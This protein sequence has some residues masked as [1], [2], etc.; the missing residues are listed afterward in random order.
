VVELRF[1]DFI[2]EGFR[3]TDKI[4]VLSCGLFSFLWSRFLFGVW[5]NLMMIDLIFI[6]SFIHSLS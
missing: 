5:G 1:T 2:A 4:C 3:I 6:H